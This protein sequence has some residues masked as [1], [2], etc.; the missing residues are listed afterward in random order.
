MKHLTMLRDAAEVTGYSL[1]SLYSY[2]RS[3]VNFPAP[4]VSAGP[5]NLFLRRE[6]ITWA[7]RRRARIEARRKGTGRR[8][9][10]RETHFDFG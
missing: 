6:L 1:H 7:K 5:S 3:D 2:A 10:A 9:V 8:K 4:R